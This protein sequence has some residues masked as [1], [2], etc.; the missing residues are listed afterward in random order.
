MNNMMPAH[1]Q[2]TVRDC[3]VCGR[4]EGDPVFVYTYDFLTKVRGTN[5]ESLAA[6][7]WTKDRT[8]T[9]VRCRNCGC[10]YVRD[11][12]LYDPDMDTPPDRSIDESVEAELKKRLA[13]ESFYHSD[14]KQWIARTLAWQAYTRQGRDIAFLDYGAGGGTTVNMV[15]AM[16]VKH[17]VA[18]DPYYPPHMKAVFKRICLPGIYCVRSRSELDALGPFD[19]VTFQAAF[20][21][22]ADPR[23]ELETIFSLMSPGGFLY[24]NN[25]CMD[26]DKELPY[27]IAA[28]RI[29]RKDR[30]SHYHPYH[31]NYLMPREFDKLLRSV[32][33]R[34]TPWIDY[35]PVTPLRGNAQ[36]WI[37][38]NLK[39]VVRMTQNTL[40]LP[41]RRE[42]FLAE[43]P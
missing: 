40:G 14:Q 29:T 23:G 9:I 7:G 42:I 25:P 18:Y 31:L 8:S 15:R 3:I 1:G 41:Y 17:V 20:E 16:G 37:V 33:F 26:L 13:G 22:V 2:P 34:V 43:K 19:A 30:I 11:P 39:M 38:R 28:N 27:L 5:P 4:D 21:H 6:R 10:K 24:V 35:V 32:G 36:A 12:F